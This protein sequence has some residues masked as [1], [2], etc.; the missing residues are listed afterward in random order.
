MLPPTRRQTR[1]QSNG[2]G[3]LELRQPRRREG[4]AFSGY[5]L[6]PSDRSFVR[7]MEWT[8]QPY[9]KVLREAGGLEPGVDEGTAPQRG[10]AAILREK[11]K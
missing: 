9:L 1:F 6:A 2:M 4:A 5:A 7:S 10:D 11:D 3:D 8:R